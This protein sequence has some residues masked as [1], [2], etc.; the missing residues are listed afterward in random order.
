LSLS[1]CYL[2]LS[3]LAAVSEGESSPGDESDW[4]G[5]RWPAPSPA[6]PGNGRMIRPWH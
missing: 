1:R 3:F 5:G 4:Q 6:C 2:A